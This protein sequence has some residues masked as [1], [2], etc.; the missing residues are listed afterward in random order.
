[1]E[2]LTFM[3]AVASVGKVHREIDVSAQGLKTGVIERSDR[4]HVAGYRPDRQ[5]L[6]AASDGLSNY[7]LDKKSPNA[8]A[9][10]TISD[11]DGFDLSAG[12]AIKQPRKADNP[13][14]EIGHP[15]RHSFGHGEIVIESD[16]GIVAP[17][18]RVFVDPSMVLSQ[19]HPQHAASRIVSR[20]VVTDNN[21]GCGY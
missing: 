16:T 9:A 3:P 8:P 4:T 11:D 17:D 15:G 20:G 1:V 10:E 19:F 13:A 12:P 21:A 14:I 6:M 2:A 18:G 7:P 5:V